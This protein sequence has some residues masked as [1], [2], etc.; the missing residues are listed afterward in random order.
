MFT[1][2]IWEI[3]R[4]VD[5]VMKSYKVSNA[6]IVLGHCTPIQNIEIP[7]PNSSPTHPHH[8]EGQSESLLALRKD[9]LIP[10]F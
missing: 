8:S 2:Q 4:K 10:L 7:A 6:V 5:W 3:L 1:I 9:Q